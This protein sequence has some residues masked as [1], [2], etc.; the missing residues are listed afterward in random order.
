MRRSIGRCWG[1]RAESQGWTD[2]QRVSS[3]VL[4]NPADGKSVDGLR[5]LEADQG[6]AAVL[7]EVERHG[8]GRLERQALKRRWRKD[9]RR[10]APSA[11]GGE[12]SASDPRGWHA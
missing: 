9:R 5:V 2:A 6:F 10:P 1:V 11:S 3:L 7:R 4:L 12:G 8:L